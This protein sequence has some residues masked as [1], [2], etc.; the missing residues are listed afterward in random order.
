MMNL[1]AQLFFIATNEIQFLIIQG[2]N[3]KTVKQTVYR[4][5]IP[6]KNI[7]AAGMKALWNESLSAETKTL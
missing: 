1:G 3:K 7:K 5:I 4:L 2:L 6:T